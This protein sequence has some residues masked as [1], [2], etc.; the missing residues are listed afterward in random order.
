V[1]GLTALLSNVDVWV[2]FNKAWLLYSTPYERA[3]SKGKVRY[4][5][6]VGMDSDMMVRT[7]G[8]VNVT[9]LYEFQRKLAE[10]TKRARRMK[11]T[12]PSGTDMEFE[13]DPERPVLVEG[14]VTGPGEYMLFGQ[15]D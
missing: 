8:R 7:I 10:V 14:E 11:V 3:L 9:L 13:N 5:C 15:V 12:T 2:E 4:L 1:R 6:L